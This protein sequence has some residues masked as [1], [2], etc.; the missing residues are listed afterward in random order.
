MYKHFTT[1]I[2]IKLIYEKPEDHPHPPPPNKNNQC[3]TGKKRTVEGEDNS[4]GDRRVIAVVAVAAG[5]MQESEQPE[6]G[7]TAAAEE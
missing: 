5:G 7:G 2:N 1:R 4:P 6:P 3:P